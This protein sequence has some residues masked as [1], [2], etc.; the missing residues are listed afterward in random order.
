MPSVEQVQRAYALKKGKVYKGPG[1]V[2]LQVRMV[3]EPVRKYHRYSYPTR[4][5]FG[6]LKKP[7]GQKPLTAEEL[8]KFLVQE[9]GQTKTIRAVVNNYTFSFGPFEVVKAPDKTFLVTATGTAINVSP[10]V[11]Y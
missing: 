8:K 1:V 3:E 4:M 11:H 6:A 9:F 5:V 7:F 10:T 2:L